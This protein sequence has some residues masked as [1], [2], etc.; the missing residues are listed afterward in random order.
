M[1]QDL[2]AEQLA[3]RILECRLVDLKSLNAALSDLDS[4]SV[5]HQELVNL[6]LQRELL[7]NW[8]VTR[9]LE[10][11][12][13]GYFYGDWKVLYLVGAGT[14]ARVYRG[15]NSKKE[16]KAIKVL[17]N[18]YSSD[19]G[20]KEQFLREARM[21]M[22]LRHPNIVPIHE[23]DEFQNRTYMIMDFVEGQNLRDYVLTHRQ[24]DLKIALSLARDLAAGLDYAYKLGISHRDMK[25]SN[26]LL[27]TKGTARLVDFGLAATAGKTEDFSPRSIDYAGL[28]KMTGV[29]R[30]DRRSDIFFLGC[31]LY[32][33]ISGQPAMDEPRERMKRL[34]PRRFQ[35]IVPITTLVK[36]LPH[37]VVILL[38]RMME[39]D[40]E[41]RTQTPELVVREIEG[42]I[43]AL[44]AGEVEAYNEELAKEE[45]AKYERLVSKENEGEG[46]NIMVIES[47]TKLQDLL[48]TKLKD[49]G[50]RPIIISDPRRAVQRFEDLDPAEDRPAHCIMIG[51]KGLGNV[52]IQALNFLAEYEGTQHIPIVLLI[53]P[54]MKKHLS[55]AKLTDERVALALPLKFKLVR[56]TLLKLIKAADKKAALEEEA[57]KLN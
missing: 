21:V 16:V 30:D 48:R 28:E 52:G 19:I 25:L 29:K 55:K 13:K 24:L 40:P 23:V 3:Q 43:K 54:E 1:S 36:D 57:Q 49:V 17:R 5:P 4:Q 22:K 47:N 42:A 8:Q 53:T 27:S 39:L 37:R 34:S 7:T 14:F 20:Q 32:H 6:L 38:H 26:V 31:M 15:V 12:I 50:Y 11:Q 33:M 35:E 46:R 10:R 9:L 41:K 45:A 51:C 18:R 2:T 56:Q 44:E